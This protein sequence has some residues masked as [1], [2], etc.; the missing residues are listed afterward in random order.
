MKFAVFLKKHDFVKFYVLAN[1]PY[2]GNRFSL[3]GCHI[4]NSVF[5]GLLNEY[6]RVQHRQKYKTDRRVHYKSPCTQTSRTQKIVNHSNTAMKLKASTD[7]FTK[8][9]D[10][11]DWT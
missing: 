4:W 2:H 5:Y 8:L 7:P 9:L 11:T 6:T 1:L 3:N 10:L